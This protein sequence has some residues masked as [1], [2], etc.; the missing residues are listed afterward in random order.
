MAGGSA[1]RGGMGFGRMFGRSPTLV[2]TDAAQPPHA[3][4]E[5]TWIDPQQLD[6][7]GAVLS[8]NSAEHLG[9]KRR[10]G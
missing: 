6:Q 10:G 8:T 2:G 7:R 9:L 3:L 1:T 4:V 5:G